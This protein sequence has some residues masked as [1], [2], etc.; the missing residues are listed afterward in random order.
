VMHNPMLL[1]VCLETVESAVIAGE[2]DDSNT[3]HW[4]SLG[5][6][7]Q[8]RSGGQLKVLYTAH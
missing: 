7:I 2:L 4:L 1:E 6:R 3:K 8:Y 5:A